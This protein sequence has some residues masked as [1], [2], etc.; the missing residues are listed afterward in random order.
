MR[1]TLSTVPQ[2]AVQKLRLALVLTLVV[3]LGEL[4][5]GLLANSLALLSDAG[6]VF[7]D[8]LA[9]LFSYYGVTQAARPATSSMTFG[10][11][12]IGILIALINAITLVG[13][14]L[15]I[16]YLAYLRF[17]APQP[18]ESQLL[19]VVAV[20][21][22]GVNLGV[23][24]MLRPEG[25][26]SL[27]VRSALLHVLGDAL[28]SLGVIVGGTIMLLTAWYWVDPAISV[29]I[30]LIILYGAWR[31]LGEGVAIVLEAAPG[32]LDV[33]ELIEAVHHVPGIKSIHDLHT[34]SIAPNLHAL[35]CHVVVEDRPISQASAILAS[36]N[37][38]LQTRFNI[39]HSTI[40]FETAGY[41]P[42]ALYCSLSPTGSPEHHHLTISG[43]P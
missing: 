11:H 3:L 34:W 13:I 40:Q 4:V 39:G 5:G 30:G 1:A 2:P 14:T 31:I 21:G 43:E 22:F 7:T 25:R 19:L 26:H 36:L 10:Y 17:L 41:E 37:R 33:A 35:S 12:R 20:L 23:A 8:L 28:S 9:L 32:H 27:N 16:F 18:V 38:L 29:F 24:L 6:H 42:D 15:V